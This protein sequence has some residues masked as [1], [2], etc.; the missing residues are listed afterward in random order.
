MA[1]VKRNFFDVVALVERLQTVKIHRDYV[2]RIVQKAQM[3]HNKLIAT[4][5][6][7]T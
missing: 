2:V 7:A 3:Q 5:F 1:Y 4:L 6:L